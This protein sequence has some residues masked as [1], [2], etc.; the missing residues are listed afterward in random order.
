[1]NRLLVILFALILYAGVQQTVAAAAV[2]AQQSAKQTAAPA[3]GDFGSIVGEQPPTVDIPVTVAVVVIA[4]LLQALIALLID[5]R[6]PATEELG[7]SHGHDRA[8]FPSST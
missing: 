3:M 2:T 1:M 5:S 4:L 7:M 8:I 6:L